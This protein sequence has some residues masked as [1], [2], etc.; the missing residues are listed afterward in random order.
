[1]AEESNKVVAE[2]RENFGKGYARRLRAAGKIPAVI[3]GHG[4]DP[5][6]VAVPAHHVALLLRKANAILEI[7]VD[8]GSHL[9]LVKDVQKDPVRQ[10]IEHLDLLAVRQGEKVEVEIPVH[11]SGEPFSGTVALVELNTLKLEAEA[12]HIPEFVVIDIEGAV[13]GTQIHAKDVVL[14]RGSVLA[15]D[16]DLLVVNIVVPAAGRGTDEES[17]TEAPAAE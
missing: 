17:A 2:R 12:T 11:L 6:H 16:A 1:M 4:G 13:E 7:E 15:D 10:I 8:G 5:L 9:T 14:P 3:Y